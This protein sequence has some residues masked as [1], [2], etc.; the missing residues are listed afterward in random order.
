MSFRIVLC[1]FIYILRVYSMG[2]AVARLI[3][4]IDQIANLGFIINSRMR[5]LYRMEPTYTR[6]L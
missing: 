2:D 5:R 1:E 3:A 6:Q 4:S